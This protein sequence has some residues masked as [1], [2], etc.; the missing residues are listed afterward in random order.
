[1]MKQTKLINSVTVYVRFPPAPRT[2]KGSVL[3]KFFSIVQA[4]N[5][6]IGQYKLKT[7]TPDQIFDIYK[8]EQ[9]V[10]SVKAENDSL[11][12]KKV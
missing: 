1:M 3:G 2:Y 6:I 4:E 11:L 7:P 10:K 12:L 9:Y 5:Y 8:D